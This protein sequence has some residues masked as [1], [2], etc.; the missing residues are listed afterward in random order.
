MHPFRARRASPMG[1][2][3][4]PRPRRYR[5]SLVVKALRARSQASRARTTSPS[6]GRLRRRGW[7]QRLNQDAWDQVRQLIKNLR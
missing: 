2:R 3:F 4:R 7:G 6:L 5:Q 1:G